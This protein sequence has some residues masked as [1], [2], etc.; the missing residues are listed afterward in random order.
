MRYSIL[1]CKHGLA[2][3]DEKEGRWT[4]GDVR[5][6][7]MGCEQTH[8]HL[9]GEGQGQGQVHFSSPLIPASKAAQGQV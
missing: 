8:S 3:L 9:D 6:W 4:V 1:G 7:R 2:M 5:A